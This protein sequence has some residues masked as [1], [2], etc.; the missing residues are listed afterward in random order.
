M[1]SLL[2][3]VNSLIEKGIGDLSRL[4]HI[5]QTIENNKQLYESDRNYLDGLISKY[6]LNEQKSAEIKSEHTENISTEMSSNTTE[7]TKSQDIFCGNCGK[8]NDS[9][10]E[11]CSKCGSPLKTKPRVAQ[12]TNAY[13]RPVE[14]KSESITLLLSILLGLFGLQGVG[15]LYVGKIGKGIGILIGSIILAVVAIIL[16]ATGIGAIVGIPLLIV[17]LIM[18]IWQIIDSRNLCREYNRYLEQHQRPPE[19]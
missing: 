13:Q 5:K 9:E 2:E 8:P 6:L 17:Y 3:H 11:F 14:W 16:I 18:F 19:W 15:H 12:N 7:N 1:A 10:N 4:D